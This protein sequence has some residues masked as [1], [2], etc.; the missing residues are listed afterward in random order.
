ML[1]ATSLS[2]HIGILFLDKQLKI[3][4]LSWKIKNKFKVDKD[5]TIINKIKKTEPKWLSCFRSI[6]S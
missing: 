5:K 2:I 1:V 6:F 4:E 3:E